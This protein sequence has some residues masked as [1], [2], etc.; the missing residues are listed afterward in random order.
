MPAFPTSAHDMASSLSLWRVTMTKAASRSTSLLGLA[1]SSS[2]W[3]SRQQGGRHD[4]GGVSESLH[5]IHRLAVE[6]ESGVAVGAG[7]G[8]WNLTPTPSDTPPPER[9]RLLIL[10]QIV[11]PT[12]D[13]AVADMNFWGPFSFKLT[14]H[15]E[16]SLRPSTAFR[17][18]QMSSPSLARFATL[19]TPVSGSALWA[20]SSACAV[21]P[22]IVCSHLPLA[23]LLR[24][25]GY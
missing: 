10:P 14:A 4:P 5:L 11:P 21:L 16:F 7:L 13:Q 15:L 9:P 17:H 23:H 24:S 18:A 3:T 12:R 20:W 2:P 6:R 19:P 1:Y 8:F 25:S 22:K